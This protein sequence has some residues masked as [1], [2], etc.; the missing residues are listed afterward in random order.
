[1][2]DFTNFEEQACSTVTALC[3]DCNWNG[4]STTCNHL[5]NE[6]VCPSCKSSNL[7]LLE[8]D[9]EPGIDL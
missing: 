5:A 7:V 9:D 6:P 8:P 1:M 2:I 3:L 4:P